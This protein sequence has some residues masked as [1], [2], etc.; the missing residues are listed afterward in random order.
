[1]RRIGHFLCLNCINIRRPT[2]CIC[3]NGIYKSFVY[4]LV[5]REV[6]AVFFYAHTT[7]SNKRIMNQESKA[8]ATGYVEVFNFSQERM[9]VRAQIIVGEPWFVAKDVCRILEI[10]KY[11]DAVA[12]LDDDERE[13]VLMDTLGGT[14][15]M[16]AVN[17]SG[18]YHLIFQSRKPEARKFRRW[19]TS[20]VLPSIRRK[21]YYGVKAVQADYLDVRDVPYK[22]MTWRGGEVRVVEADGERWYSLNDIHSC[23]GA[24]TESSQSV[25]RLNARQVLARKL[26]LYGTPNPGWFVNELGVRLLLCASRKNRENVQLTLDFDGKEG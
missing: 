17:E 2:P 8:S 5:R 11:R 6:G 4:G 18:L 22:V 26:W 25:R 1:M 9:P 16:V 24:R 20:E 23:I 10:A 19:V 3:C 15:Q 14:Q 12:R 13:S 21:G 7:H